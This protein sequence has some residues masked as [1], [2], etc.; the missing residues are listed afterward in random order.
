MRRTDVGARRP[1]VRPDPGAGDTA[2]NPGPR[3]LPWWRCVAAACVA[4]DEWS[5]L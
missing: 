3:A 4:E 5:E 1:R 2:G